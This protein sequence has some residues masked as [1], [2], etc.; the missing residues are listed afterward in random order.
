VDLGRA[1]VVLQIGAE[2]GDEFV[3]AVVVVMVIDRA[4][5][6]LGVPGGADFAAGFAGIQQ[7]QQP[8][9]ASVFEPLI[10]A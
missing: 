6:L 1:R 4:H 3:R 8:A 10:S 7:A 2:A 5:D 9:A